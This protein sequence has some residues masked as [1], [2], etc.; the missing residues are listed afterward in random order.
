[1]C[2][3]ECVCPPHFM[4]NLYF[5]RFFEI[6]VENF[7]QSLWSQSTNLR[8]WPTWYTLAL[9]YNTF[10]IVL[11]MFRAL[12]AHHQEVELYWCSFWYRPLSEWP[13]DAQVGRESVHRTAPDWEDD[14]RCCINT[15]QPPDDEHIMLE[16]CTGM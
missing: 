15:V 3:V 7:Y 1:M 10:V 4:E 2:F 6:Y 11:Y 16:T 8:Q 9:F 5:E 14:T 13:S 12:Y